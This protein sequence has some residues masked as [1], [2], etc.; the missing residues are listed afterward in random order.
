MGI[1]EIPF[2]TKLPTLNEY[3]NAE[4]GDRMAAANMKKKVTNSIMVESLN[5]RNLID[6]NIVYDIE[7]LWETANN[8][9]DP[10]NIFFGVKFILDGVVKAG[11]LKSDGRKNIRNIYNKIETTGQNR[12]IMKLNKSI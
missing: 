5:F 8:R 6:P 12:V 9:I 10:D 2:Y 7:L 4:R 3:I 1:L 11:I